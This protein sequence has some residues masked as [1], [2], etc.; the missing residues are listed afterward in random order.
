MADTITVAS[1]PTTVDVTSEALAGMA[2]LSGVV[3]DYNE[4]SQIRTITESV[5]A[6]VE[7]QGVAA[8]ATALQAISYSALGAFG[9]DPGLA[10]QAIG[11]E[12]F[13]TAASGGPPAP[14]AVSIPQGTLVQTQGGTQFATVSAA[15]LAQ[16]QN[17][18]DVPIQAVVGGSVGNVIGGAI[19]QLV[20]SLTYPLVVTNASPTTGGTDATT[21]AQALSLLAA[22][23]ASLV[24]GSPVSVANAPIGVNAS[25]SNEYV[26]YATCYEPWVAAGSGTGS[27]TAGFTVYIDNG[28]GA[29]SSGLIAAVTSKLNGNALLQQ[30]GYRPAGVPYSVL[31]VVPI[32]VDVVVAAGINSFGVTT[33]VSGNIISAVQAYFQTINFGVTA[34]QADIAAYS[35]NAAQ[36]VLTSL[37]ASLYYHSA[38]GTAVTAVTGAGFNRIILNNLSVTVTAS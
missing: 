27:G 24:G 32:L 9:V 23:I 37:S 22:I 33:T 30:N 26:Q 17:T 14:Q 5:G 15:I 4:G 1:P 3:T 36:G 7:Q 21:P 20:S 34:Y 31:A 18:I 11:T 16:G 28:A 29:A 8:Q 38:S 19:N 35:A 10:R 25:G 6:V 13:A 2:A 12:T